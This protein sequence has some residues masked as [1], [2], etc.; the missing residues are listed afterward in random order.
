VLSQAALCREARKSRNGDLLAPTNLSDAQ[1]EAIR[2]ALRVIQ[3]KKESKRQRQGAHSGSTSQ[4]QRSAYASILH[5]NA[6]KMRIS[7]HTHVRH[8]M[9]VMIKQSHDYPQLRR[10]L[11]H[12]KLLE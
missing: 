5:S 4:R 1:L 9:M 12:P 3:L 8:E 2:R 7:Y 6:I 11:G 10:L